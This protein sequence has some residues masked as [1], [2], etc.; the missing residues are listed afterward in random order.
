METIEPIPGKFIDNTFVVTD[1]NGIDAK[2]TITNYRRGLWGWLSHLF[3]RSVWIDVQGEKQEKLALLRNTVEKLRLY[4]PV[5]EMN[6]IVEGTLWERTG[7]VFASCLKGP[8]LGVF[9]GWHDVYSTDLQIC[10]GVAVGFVFFEVYNKKSGKFLGNADVDEI[11]DDQK[12]GTIPPYN[13]QSK[14][15]YVRFDVSGG[16]VGDPRKQERQK[17]TAKAL[18]QAVV[19]YGNS[20]GVNGQ[21]QAIM[22][23]KCAALFCDLGMSYGCF[24]KLGCFNEVY[25]GL[26]A[27]WNQDPS[28]SMKPLYVT[29]DCI[30]QFAPQIRHNSIFSGP[31]VLP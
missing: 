4:V 16:A 3:G 5:S 9:G 7:A 30:K 26:L 22:P 15:F 2:Y 31:S 14:C 10:G 13:E 18:L 24:D 23:S 25:A 27:K 8:K 12:F 17:A 11:R 6:E 1:T 21:I 29:E 28:A 19:E 20:R